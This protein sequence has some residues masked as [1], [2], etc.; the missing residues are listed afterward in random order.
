MTTSDD[1]LIGES[2]AIRQVRASIAKAAQS[3][4]TV[5][6]EGESG[7]GKELVARAI[8]AAGERRAQPLISLNCAA[9]PKDLI[10][11]ELFGHE[12]G[13]FTG[14]HE[15]KTGKFEQAHMGTLFLD[16]IGEMDISLQAKLLRAIE[17][18][19]I[20]R[21]GGGKPIQVDIRLIAATNCHL[22]RA[23]AEG[24]FREDLYFRLNVLTI[25][26]P[27]LR[28]RIED[29]PALALHFISRFARKAG[30]TVQGITRECL[31][32]LRRYRWPG[33]VRE[34]RNVIQ[35]A[36]AMGSSD[37][38]ELQDLPSKVFERTYDLTMNEAIDEL[39]REYVTG[40]LTAANGSW[41]KAAAMLK[42]HPRTLRRTINKLNAS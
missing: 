7:T 13:A 2:A 30:R 17:E 3:D 21:L 33:N 31:S 8:H 20:E 27:P 37:F 10:E 34:L 18:G 42:M 25:R 1:L 26:T 40:A 16:E 22:R 11:S 6:I 14:A 24:R 41:K 15:L 28:D 23:I 9:L 5:L 32:I 4:F 36:I 35:H 12:K 19:E 38:I 29:V 39:K